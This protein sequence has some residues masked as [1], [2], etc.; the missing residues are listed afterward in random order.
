MANADIRNPIVINATTSALIQSGDFLRSVCFVSF[1]DSN[2]NAGE[3]ADVD[4]TDYDEYLN[5]SKTS[6]AYRLSNFFSYASNKLATI[7]ELGAQPRGSL[8][9]S[10][11]ALL[12]FAGIQ[13]G[14]TT[15]AYYKWLYENKMPYFKLTAQNIIL[16]TTEATI[17][18]DMNFK[19]SDINIVNSV[20]G[21]NIKIADDGT[22][23]YS[24]AQSSV[25]NMPAQV[26]ST[27]THTSANGKQI[28]VITFNKSVSNAVATAA[29]NYTME[30]EDLLKTYLGTKTGWNQTSYTNWLTANKKTDSL[31]SL[32]EYCESPNVSVDYPQGYYNYLATKNSAMMLQLTEAN[33][34]EYLGTLGVDEASYNAWLL[35][36]GAESTDFTEKLELLKEFIDDGNKRC[37]IY[38]LPKKLTTFSGTSGFT[39]GYI[40]TNS[41]RYFALEGDVDT[42]WNAY[43]GMKSVI[44]ICNNGADESNDVVGAILGRFASSQFD[45]SASLKA[46][47][48]N[49]KFVSGLQFNELGSSAQRKLIQ[50]NVSF[51]S[52][53][54]GNTLIMN[55]R[56]MDSRAIDYWYQWDITAFNIETAIVTLLLNG[57]NNP[58][59]VVQYNQ[60]GIDTINASIVSTLNTMIGYGCVTEFGAT[61]NSATSAIENTGYILAVDY[62][63]Y[64]ASAPADYQNEIYQGI[65]FYLRIGKY[66]RQVVLNVSL[67]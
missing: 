42:D 60:N 46:S 64:I 16:G 21:M 31:A 52:S 50:S 9:A 11:D 6:F 17:K 3:Y 63:S 66:I 19:A 48:M 62:Y 45:I 29:I 27:L 59:Y 41:K 51:I 49:Y 34:L 23:T 30:D 14:F 37:Y 8:P 57:V 22:L 13:A 20:A 7:L 32:K 47:P 12:Q 18:V 36:A 58:N 53:K 44:A 56:C 28:G 38:A 35:T 2:L 55:G 4:R 67:N 25:A 40:D 24:I 54:A 65:S 1:G 61:Y 43:E 26:T 5:G 15:D 10:Y 39:R 33:L